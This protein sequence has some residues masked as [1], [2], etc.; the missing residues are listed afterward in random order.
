MKFRPASERIPKVKL[1]ACNAMGITPD[2]FNSDKRTRRFVLARQMFWHK[3][4][5]DCPN[6]SLS[7]LGKMCGRIRDHSTVIHG[8]NTIDNLLRFDRDVQDKYK[9]FLSN[10]P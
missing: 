10:L 9:V 1:A 2:E 5:K 3:M 4:R 6:V 7:E 8:I